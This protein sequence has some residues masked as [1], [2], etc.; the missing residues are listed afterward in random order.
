MTFTDKICHTAFVHTLGANHKHLSIYL[1]LKLIK[2]ENHFP[3]GIFVWNVLE[4][5]VET[6]N[7]TTTFTPLLKKY[8]QSCRIRKVVQKQIFLTILKNAERKRFRRAASCLNQNMIS[9]PRYEIIFSTLFL[10]FFFTKL[11]WRTLAKIRTIN[12]FLG[13]SLLTAIEKQ[14]MTFHH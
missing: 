7:I 13:I 2:T 8:L 9:R 12:N 3:Y 6:G 11:V 14:F 10:P 4:Y 1:W 5:S